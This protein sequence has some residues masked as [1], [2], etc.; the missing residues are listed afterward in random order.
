MNGF[1][2]VKQRV[3]Y[4]LDHSWSYHANSYR[5]KN[6][7]ELTA[8]QYMTDNLTLWLKGHS[9]TEVILS[10]SANKKRL[11]LNGFSPT[12]LVDQT[13]WRR[14][15]HSVVPVGNGALVFSYNLS[16]KVLRSNRPETD[17]P[18][19][20]GSRVAF[21]LS[22]GGYVLWKDRINLGE[23]RWF[24][25]RGKEDTVI[26]DFFQKEKKLGPEYWPMR[27]GG[28]WWQSL[29]GSKKGRLYTVLMN[30]RLIAGIGN[31]IALEALHRI[32][33]PLTTKASDLNGQQ[34]DSLAIAIRQVTA[35][36][37]NHHDALRETEILTVSHPTLMRGELKLVAEG[38]TH[39]KGFSIYGRTNEPCP[40]CGKGIIIK[41]KLN[42]RPTYSCTHCQKD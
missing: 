1:D 34:W 41:G 31:I 23:I 24:P 12:G 25:N 33:T 4:P 2:T 22:N 40:T 26:H 18:G 10:Q 39:A 5:A 32:G 7:P 27:R 8:T 3:K 29:L 42:G 36:S 30:Q 9:I 21:K 16:G 15:K 6:M 35:A 38:H 28:N 37:L 19:A 13:A 20:A 14:G 17:L 11:H